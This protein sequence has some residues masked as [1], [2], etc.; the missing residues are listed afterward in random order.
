MP[1][2][3]AA[4]NPA[5]LIEQAPL[6]DS[7]RDLARRGEPMR[8][9]KKTQLIIEGDLSDTLYIVVQGRLRAYSVG[10]DGREVTFGVYGP[11]EYVGE[12]SLDGGPRSSSVDAPEAGWVV[13]V[14]R[15]TL[16]QHLAEQPQFAFDLL[17]K[18]IRRARATTRNLRLIALNG[19]YGR[20]KDYLESAA[21]PLSDGGFGLDPAPSQLEMSRLIGCTRAMVGR[22]FKDLVKGG[23]IEVGRRSV[24]LLKALPAKW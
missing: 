5:W 15:R 10:S 20:L 3:N 4:A 9:R 22:I 2:P 7:L 17:A 18:V 23:W 21:V 12:M 19:V 8:V 24:R 1:K 13:M 11:G 6:T 14:T 16:E